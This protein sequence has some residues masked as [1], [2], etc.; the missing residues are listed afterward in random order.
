MGDKGL[1]KTYQHYRLNLSTHGPCVV[2][3][4]TEGREFIPRSSRVYLLDQHLLD[5]ETTRV[6]GR[7]NLGRVKEIHVPWTK[8]ENVRV[9]IVPYQFAKLCFQA[10]QADNELFAARIIEAKVNVVG[11]WSVDID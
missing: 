10:S 3:N 1:M 7:T 11:D 6:I 9:E 8:L 2:A 5:E 4:L